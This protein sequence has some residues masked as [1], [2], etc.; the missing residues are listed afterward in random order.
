MPKPKAKESKSP[1]RAIAEQIALDLFTG[2]NGKIAKHLTLES[3]AAS[4]TGGLDG[5]CQSAVV[6]L[7]ERVLDRHFPASAKGFPNV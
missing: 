3:P 1:N 2:G 4:H 5:W 7:I 6:D